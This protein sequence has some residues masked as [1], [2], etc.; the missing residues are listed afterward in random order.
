MSAVAEA[1]GVFGV[2][3]KKKYNV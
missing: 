2:I 3:K 1:A